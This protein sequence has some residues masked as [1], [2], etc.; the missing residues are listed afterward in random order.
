MSTNKL[1][2]RRIKFTKAKS[3]NIKVKRKKHSGEI[4]LI[5]TARQNKNGMCDA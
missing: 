4:E 2:R 5:P 1:S 3:E